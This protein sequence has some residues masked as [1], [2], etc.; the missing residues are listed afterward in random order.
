MVWF[1][2]RRGEYVRCE[3]RQAPD[4]RFELVVTEP[5][6]IERVESFDDSQIMARRQ[7]ELEHGLTAD[8]W[9]GPSGRS[10]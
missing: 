5:G 6:G 7:V 8:G 2:E 1:F 4:G 3:T 9:N 10:V